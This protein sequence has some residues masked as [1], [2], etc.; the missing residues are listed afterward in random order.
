MICAW[1]IVFL[2]NYIAGTTA[3]ETS[4]QHSLRVAMCQFEIVDGN[5][6]ENMRRAEEYIRKAARNY[7]KLIC[8]PE[9]AD[10]GWLYEHARRDAFP[11]PGAYTD[12]LSRLAKELKVYIC[13]GCLER[14]GDKTYNSA[15]LI[16]TQGNVV[17]KHR[18]INTLAFLTKDLYDAGRKEDLGTVDTESGRMGITICADNFDLNIPQKVADQGAWLLIAPHG[19]AAEKEKLRRN[20]EEFQQHIRRIAK[21]TKMWVIGTNTCRGPIAAGEWKGRP[22]SGCSTIARPDGSVAA[23]AKF[24]SPEIVIS[25]IPVPLAR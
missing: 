9:A 2:S 7:A 10:W 15:V 22:H 23:V 1:T 17:L 20:A 19:F 25:N 11:I 8:L 16:D 4:E 14:D 5:I 6:A 12:M 24:N 3:P 21:H 18:K 13:G